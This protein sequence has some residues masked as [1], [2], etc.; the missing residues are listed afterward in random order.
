M[1]SLRSVRIGDHLAENQENPDWGLQHHDYVFE[2]GH[3]FGVVIAGPESG[4]LQ[5]SRHPTTN[6]EIRLDLLLSRVDLPVGGGPAARQ[7]AFR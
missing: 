6:N 1:R 7:R 4:R 3:R 2:A 5:F